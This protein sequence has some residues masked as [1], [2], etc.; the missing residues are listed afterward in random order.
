M[1]QDPTQSIT[2]NKS[3]MNYITWPVFLGLLQSSKRFNFYLLVI[4]SG[5]YKIQLLLCISKVRHSIA[6]PVQGEVSIAK[7]GDF[8][9]TVWN[10][11]VFRPYHNEGK[12]Y[13]MH[14][15]WFD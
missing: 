14:Y 10:L 1:I 2:Q 8:S 5:G 9:D 3:T 7:M 6:T 15:R 4:G 13:E 11:I 12:H